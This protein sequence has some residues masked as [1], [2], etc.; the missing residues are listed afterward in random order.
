MFLIDLNG[1]AHRDG[2]TVSIRPHDSD[3]A[4]GRVGR[5]KIK[6]PAR[7]IRRNGRAAARTEKRFENGG[8][9]TRYMCANRSSSFRATHAIRWRRSKGSEGGGGAK[10]PRAK[11][12]P[13]GSRPFASVKSAQS[14]RPPGIF[15]DFQFICRH[16]ART[17][18]GQWGN[19]KRSRN[20]NVGIVVANR[21]RGPVPCWP[22]DTRAPNTLFIE[23]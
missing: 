6:C 4:T 14:P 7:E 9:T 18:H 8:E 12:G 5:N 2:S 13:V 17:G 16:K 11:R 19:A 15:P 10:G 22:S 3:Y 20:A 1:P 23:F 21:I